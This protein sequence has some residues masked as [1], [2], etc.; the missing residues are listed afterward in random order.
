MFVERKSKLKGTAAG[1]REK[2]VVTSGLARAF[3]KEAKADP[4]GRRGHPGGDTRALHDANVV[5]LND[6]LKEL[7][8]R[9]DPLPAQ[10]RNASAPAYS[11]IAKHLNIRVESFRD[12]SE[13][14]SMVDKAASVLGVRVTLRE[15]VGEIAMRE[16]LE[17]AVE[18]RRR[19]CVAE[20]VPSDTDL[21]ALRQTACLGRAVEIIEVRYRKTIH[22]T[23]K[24]RLVGD[25]RRRRYLSR[26]T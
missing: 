24:R 12:G 22:K 2:L 14:R 1:W 25:N 9:G 18:K 23:Q 5:A 21:K 4:N 7:T 15:N 19:E 16:L 20:G 11:A 10:T 13:L 8:S 6:Y 26:G 17:S 3:E